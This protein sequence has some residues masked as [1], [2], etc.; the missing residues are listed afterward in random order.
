MISDA[1]SLVYWFS[2]DLIWSAKN[3]V[4]TFFHLPQPEHHLETESLRLFVLLGR[5][6][7]KKKHRCV[8]STEGAALVTFSSKLG[9]Q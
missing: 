7:L 1:N 6:Q 2:L 8:V 3:E 5:H 4:N 9:D